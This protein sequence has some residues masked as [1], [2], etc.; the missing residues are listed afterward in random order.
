MGEG[1]L[2]QSNFDLPEPR[3]T[4]LFST[5][6]IGPSL[7]ITLQCT[8]FPQLTW[9]HARDLALCSAGMDLRSLGSSVL[10]TLRMGCNQG[11]CSVSEAVTSV[12][13]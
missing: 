5:R 10:G 11:S 13:R 9:T 7:L 6:E 4:E 2:V 3:L 8:A 12:L 1:N